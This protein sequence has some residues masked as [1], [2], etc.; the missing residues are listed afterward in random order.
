MPPAAPKIAT[1]LASTCT[2]RTLPLRE[3]GMVACDASTLRLE[4]R[5][6][7]FKPLKEAILLLVMAIVGELLQLAEV[8]IILFDMVYATL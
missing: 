6:H 4:T 5:S 2:A 3:R 1:F 8:A 7:A